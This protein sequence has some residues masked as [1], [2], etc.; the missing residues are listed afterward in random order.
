MIGTSDFD[1][2]KFLVQMDQRA[3]ERHAQAEALH[4]AKLAQ[5]PRVNRHT[6]RAMDVQRRKA[7]S[8]HPST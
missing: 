5:H 8:H 4:Y 7:E 3:R 6:Q 1:N 2:L